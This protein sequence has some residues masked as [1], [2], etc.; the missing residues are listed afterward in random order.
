MASETAIAAAILETVRA[1][2]PG[3]TA[4]PSEV[5]RALDPEADAWRDLM[6]AVRRVA[7]ALVREGR[8]VVTRRGEPVDPEAGGGPIR[9]GLPRDVTEA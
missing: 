9:L 8:L 6:P 5:A 3:R 1:R 7:G 4:C 2:G